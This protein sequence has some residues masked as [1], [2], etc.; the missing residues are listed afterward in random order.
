M[1]KMRVEHNI[2]N[3][4]FSAI[5]TIVDDVVYA[6]LKPLDDTIHELEKLYK[7]LP[8]DI[9][10]Y[11]TIS[12]RVLDNTFIG[13]NSLPLNVRDILID[14]YIEG[15]PIINFYINKKKALKVTLE[16][17]LVDYIRLKPVEILKTKIT[18]LYNVEQISKFDSMLDI[19]K[20]NVQFTMPDITIPDMP[21]T[22]CPNLT[23]PQSIAYK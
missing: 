16:G 11:P 13:I 7:S 2:T 18:T 1:G 3:A 19:I 5:C 17:F 20:G 9:S 23:P 8:D 21:E 15:I 6:K 4:R 12:C 22:Y 14:R 10:I